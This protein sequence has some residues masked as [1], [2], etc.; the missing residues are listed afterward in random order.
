V[1]YLSKEDIFKT[2]LPQRDVEVPEWGG[3]VRVRALSGSDRDEYDAS[4]LRAQPDGTVLRVP[5]SRA[6][7]VSLAVIKDNGDPMFNVGDIGRLG[8]QSAT[9]LDRVVNAIVELSGLSDQAVEDAAGNSD[10]AL[11]GDSGSTSPEN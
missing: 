5:G 8:L 7:L 1:T 2:E 9:A 3:I 4:M 11:S 10:A 6:K